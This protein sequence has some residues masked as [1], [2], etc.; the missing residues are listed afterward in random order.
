MSASNGAFKLEKFVD[1]L[2][3]EVG[4]DRW[5]LILTADHGATP[6]PK[7]SEA[8]VISPISPHTLTNRPVVDSAE[9]VY[10]LVVP[11][12]HEGTTLVVDGALSIPITELVAAH[13]RLDDGLA[14]D[15]MGH[16]LT[17]AHVLERVLAGLE[18]DPE[19]CGEK[20]QADVAEFAE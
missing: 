10:E 2:N 9:R 8:F 4:K 20:G 5:V 17:Y 1:F 3:T 18:C 13:Q 11:R 14:I 19:G 7:V 15:G 6:Y 16:R 12:P